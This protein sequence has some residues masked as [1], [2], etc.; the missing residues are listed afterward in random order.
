MKQNLLKGTLATTDSNEWT[1]RRCCWEYIEGLT[2]Y[3]VF[4]VKP[5]VRHQTKDKSPIMKPHKIVK[6]NPESAAVQRA[7]SRQNV[8]TFLPRQSVGPTKP[9]QTM[10]LHYREREVP[11]CDF[12]YTSPPCVNLTTYNA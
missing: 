12:Q 1:Y 2:Y 4:S 9:P 10:V 7:T 11:D 3:W 6:I 8:W 5:A